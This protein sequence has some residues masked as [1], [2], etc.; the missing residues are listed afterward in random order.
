[1][2]LE[3][4]SLVPRIRDDF[5]SAYEGQQEKC[6]AIVG[7]KEASKEEKKTNK[8]KCNM[9]EAQRTAQSKAVREMRNTKGANWKKQ[10]TR[11]PLDVPV[12]KKIVSFI[13]HK[14]GGTGNG[15]ALYIRL[16]IVQ[17]ETHVDA[18]AASSAESPMK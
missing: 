17:E 13:H 9:L 1:M 7:D 2:A 4:N 6:M 14:D 8:R 16:K 18:L 15:S 5:D 12:E 3:I 10:V 11:V